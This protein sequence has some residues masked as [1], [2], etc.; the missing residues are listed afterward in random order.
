MTQ[1]EEQEC[2]WLRVV[3]ANLE[4]FDQLDEGAT[5]RLKASK[6]RLQELNKG[7]V[8]QMKQWECPECHTMNSFNKNG[9]MG[10]CIG[11]GRMGN[12]K[13]EAESQKLIAKYKRQL[14]AR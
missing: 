9:C 6:A 14:K 5:K 7:G 12:D 10:I 8:N 2:W 1:N 3:I 13:A 4:S 11:C